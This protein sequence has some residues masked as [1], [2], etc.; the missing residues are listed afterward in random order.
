MPRRRHVSHV[1]SGTK[2]HLRHDSR[3]TLLART[4]FLFTKSLPK[5]VRSSRELSFQEALGERDFLRGHLGPSDV[6][7]STP[8]ERVSASEHVVVAQLLLFNIECL[9]H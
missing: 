9:D 8:V 3:S 1:D 2:S 6:C 4:L 5:D 7:S